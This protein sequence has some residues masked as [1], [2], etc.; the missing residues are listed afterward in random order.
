MVRNRLVLKTFPC[1]YLCHLHFYSM[2][3]HS[4]RVPS[5]SSLSCCESSWV[6]QVHWTPIFACVFSIPFPFWT[7]CFLCFIACP[8][9]ILK[10]NL[11]SFREIFP[12]DFELHLFLFLLFFFYVNY[13]LYRGNIFFSHR[14][15]CG[16]LVPQPGLEPWTPARSPNHWTAREFPRNNILFYIHSL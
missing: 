7:P 16:I 9:L 6:T 11:C 15:A 5:L 10:P 12:Y 3:L 4:S 2:P 1:S 8:Y 14:V 13:L